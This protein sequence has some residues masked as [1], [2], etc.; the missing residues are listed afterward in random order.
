MPLTYQP[1]PPWDITDWLTMGVV[2]RS[3]AKDRLKGDANVKFNSELTVVVAGLNRDANSLGTDIAG[4][5][6]HVEMNLES[7]DK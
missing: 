3:S 4:L 2:Y 6:D 1:D 7:L 5:I